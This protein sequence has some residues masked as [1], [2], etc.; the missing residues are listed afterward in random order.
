M[1][2]RLYILTV[3]VSWSPGS[4][5]LAYTERTPGNPQ[6]L[7]VAGHISLSQADEL[8]HEMWRLAADFVG[9]EG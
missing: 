7:E 5:Y 3:T 4:A 6:T 2:D 8:H 1:S 9:Y